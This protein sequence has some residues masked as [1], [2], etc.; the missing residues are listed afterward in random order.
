[1]LISSQDGRRKLDAWV[2]FQ[3][4]A[5]S[6]LSTQGYLPVAKLFLS[7]LQFLKF[8]P[9]TTSVNQL[10]KYNIN[11]IRSL[12]CKKFSFCEPGERGKYPAPS[13]YVLQNV[14]ACYD[15]LKRSMDIPTKLANQNFS[16]T[17]LTYLSEEF[18][19]FLRVL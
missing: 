4:N 6:N 1:M 16:Q 13:N 18:L 7:L 12:G 15:V 3:I 2:R 10:Q 8:E 5:I 14:F 17:L 19:K 11:D 9:A